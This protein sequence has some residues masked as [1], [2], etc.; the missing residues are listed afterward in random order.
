MMMRSAGDHQNQ[1]RNGTHQREAQHAHAIGW[2]MGELIGRQAQNPNELGRVDHID[3]KDD[4]IN[5]QQQ[6]RQEGHLHK[7]DWHRMS[8]DKHLAARQAL[9]GQRSEAEIGERGRQ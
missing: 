6:G 7:E 2:C 9:A 1:K 4:F 5:G 3:H 8:Q